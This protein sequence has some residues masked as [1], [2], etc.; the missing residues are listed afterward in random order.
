ML[1]LL[2]VR[3][4]LVQEPLVLALRA[5]LVRLI[6]LGLSLDPG[7]VIGPEVEVLDRLLLLLPH[8]LE[9]RSLH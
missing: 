1:V 8:S 6:G 9:A 7:L 4:A 2:A 3:P 5:A